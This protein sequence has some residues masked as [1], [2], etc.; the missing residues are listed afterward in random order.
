MPVYPF[1]LFVHCTSH[2]HD[3]AYCYMSTYGHMSVYY[4]AEFEEWVYP[5]RIDWTE[6]YVDK[7]YFHWGYGMLYLLGYIL[8]WGGEYIRLPEELAHKFHESASVQC[9]TQPDFYAEI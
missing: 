9:E 7:G 2:L 1:C 5:E 8:H 4:S 3:L 6:G